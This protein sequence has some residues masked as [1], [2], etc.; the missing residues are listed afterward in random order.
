MYWTVFLCYAGPLSIANAQITLELDAVYSPPAVVPTDPADMTYN[1]PEMD[2]MLEPVKV[3][4]KD[5]SS[6]LVTEPT[7]VTLTTILATNLNV[8][9]NPG[10]TYGGALCQHNKW[11]HRFGTCRYM[12]DGCIELNCNTT[13]PNY[14]LGKIEVE[15]VNGIATFDRLLHTKYTGADQRRLRFF[16]EVNGTSATLDSNAFDVDC[17]CCV[18]NNCLSS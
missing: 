10:D 6:N 12:D 17:K 1:A 7:I 13:D 2:Y 14:P 18:Y 16:A 11:T 3:L 15:T 5:S 8:P 9:G 4:L